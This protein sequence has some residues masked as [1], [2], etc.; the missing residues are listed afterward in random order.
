MATSSIDGLVSGLNT[1]DIINRLLEAE[2]APIARIQ[3]RA[4]KQDSIV[5]AWQSVSSAMGAFRTATTALVNASSFEKRTTTSS[6]ASIVTATAAPGAPVGNLS[7]RV[8]ALATAQQSMTSTS[9][10]ASDTLTGTGTVAVGVG[11]GSL[12][13]TGITASNGA[14]AGA[15]NVT[16]AATAGGQFSVSVGDAQVVVAS[17]ATSAS[18]GGLELSFG[19]GGP[20]A[21]SGSAVIAT[22]NASTTLGQLTTALSTS[23]SPVGAQIVNISSTSTADNRLVLTAK[24]TGATNTLMVGT[25]GLNGG[26]A[27]SLG[28]YTTLNA[29]SNAQVAI[30]SGAGEVI[31]QRSSNT[32]SDLLQD[33]SVSLKKADPPA[34]VVLGVDRDTST[35]IQ[36]MR[37][38][39]TSTNRLVGA[40]DTQTRYD[41]VS[42]TGGPLTGDASARSVRDAV[43][44][45]ITAPVGTGT[46]S[47][48]ASVGVTMQRNG[49]VALDEAAFT[50]ALQNDPNAVSA[51]LARSGSTASATM[52]FA[53]AA[54][55]TKAG[56][57]AVNV[58]TAAAK[59]SVTG[60]VITTLASDEEITVRMGGRTATFSALTGM[61]AN[62]AADGL[63][64]ALTSAGIRAT[65]TV[66]G[67]AITLASEQ[68]GSA[69]VLEVMSDLVGPGS[70]GLGG[71][72]ADTYQRSTGVDVA[73]TI[74][75]QAATG[76]GQVL[77]ATAGDATGLRVRV[78]GTG[79][80]AQGNIEYS[81]GVF[82]ALAAQVGTN[83]AATVLAQSSINGAKAAKLLITSQLDAY[84]RRMTLTQERLR[85]QFTQLES[86]L[87]R[88]RSEG[89]RLLAAISGLTSS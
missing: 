20:V 68:Y 72:T 11:L 67:G 52:A 85:N 60:E 64:A 4:T 47:T 13:I 59:A 44:S 39:V 35:L 48:L 75:G 63:N 17:G 71:P 53:G 12:G 34:T 21:G 50:A 65:A 83:G 30:G 62:Q 2:R 26:V 6:D 70:T 51:L 38:W 88:T 10:G 7:M 31:V 18:V 33:V 77:T 22:T 9:P 49:Q 89:D 23:G 3:S 36:L 46:Y 73:G 40:I 37:Q 14:T 61:T 58:T 66:A 54:D 78:T 80:G 69:Q 55:E 56:S 74:G 5:S 79:T 8:I 42:R 45:T 81:S 57:Y 76:T 43:T 29:A 27:T 16:I 86:V 24:N 28:T 15:R 82:G 41:A 25:T 84:E 1:T 32:I 19:G 87:S